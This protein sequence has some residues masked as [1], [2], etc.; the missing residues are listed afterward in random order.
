V[1]KF[2]ATDY[3]VTIGGVDFSTSIAAVTFDITAA[4]QEV[5]AFGD[6][7][8]QRIGGLK[9]ASISI[10]FHQDF[11]AS[12][13]DDTLFPLLGTAVAVVALPQGG[14]V[15][16]TNPSYTGTFLCTQYSPLGS[17]VGDLATL[18]VSWPL[19]SG[20]ITRATA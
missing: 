12:S 6:T 16:A 3:N 14:T 15:S 7:F 13:V 5:T 4:E 17:S 10:D 11:G 9:D 20:V 18:S 1:A 19:A 2:V 8:V